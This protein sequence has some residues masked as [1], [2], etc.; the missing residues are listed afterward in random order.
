MRT[1]LTV[2]LL[3]V[4]TFGFGLTRASAQDISCSC[5]DTPENTC[6]A[7]VHCRDGCTAVC[8]AKDTCYVS[9]RTDLLTSPLTLRFVK[10]DG[11]FIA[12]TLSE[13]VKK[14]IQFEPYP[15]KKKELYTFELKK[16]DM[17]PILSFLNERGTVTI[18]NKDLRPFFRMQRQARRRRL[19]VRFESMPAK[20]VVERLAFLS[21]FKLRIRSG[22]PTTPVSLHLN[23][24]T[25]RE[26]LEEISKQANVKITGHTQK[27]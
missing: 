18:N 2:L 19:S 26:I 12:K 27:R 13:R 22:D 7:A 11:K 1:P 24:K 23:D 9:C 21:R 25:L 14:N 5:A 8:G 16:S 3:S 4:L 10:K 15:R 20:D 17:W 6:I